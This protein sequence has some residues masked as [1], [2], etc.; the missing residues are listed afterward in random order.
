LSENDRE[1]APALAVTVNTN[2]SDQH[3]ISPVD[4]VTDGVTVNSEVFTVTDA[5]NDECDDSS[6]TVASTQC[7]KVDNSMQIPSYT[8]GVCVRA[9]V[10]ACVCVNVCM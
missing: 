3:V 6:N 9:C 4:P 10:R 7:S 2:S 5:G 1:A 8:Q